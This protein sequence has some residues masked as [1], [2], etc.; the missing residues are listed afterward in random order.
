VTDLTRRLERLE[1]TTTIRPPRIFMIEGPDSYG[2][3]QAVAELGLRLV[4]DDLVI[5]IC[6]RGDGVPLKLR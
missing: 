3:D 6:G 5:Y 1:R 2:V 4:R